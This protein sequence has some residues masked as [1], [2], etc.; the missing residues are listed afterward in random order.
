[1]KNGETKIY[2]APRV[3]TLELVV[4]RGFSLSSNY[5][6]FGEPGQGSGYIDNDYEL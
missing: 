6:G 4:E 2:A 5:G 3:E 1:M